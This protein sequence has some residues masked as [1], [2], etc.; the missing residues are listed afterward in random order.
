LWRKLQNAA[1][2][3][4]PFNAKSTKI[5]MEYEEVADFNGWITKNA[6]DLKPPVGM[7]CWWKG[8]SVIDSSTHTHTSQSLCLFPAG[9]K[10]M[11]GAGQHKIMVVGGPNV[12]KDFHLEEGEVRNIG[13][14]W[15]LL[16]P[17][18]PHPASHL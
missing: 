4:S 5:E 1:T 12:R 15:V 18:V 16:Q 17:G 6:P 3:T 2:S 14:L 11:Y 9:N 8:A 7:L 10:L 13:F